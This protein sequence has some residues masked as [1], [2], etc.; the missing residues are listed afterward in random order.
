MAKN[1]NTQTYKT[2]PCGGLYDIDKQ[3]DYKP[4]LTGKKKTQELN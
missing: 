3:I 2:S 1:N 4:T